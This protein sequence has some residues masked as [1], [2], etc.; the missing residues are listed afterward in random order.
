METKNTFLLKKRLIDINVDTLERHVEVIYL[1]F[2]IDWA[3]DEVLADTIDLVE[4]ADVCATWFVTHDTPLLKRL[5]DNPKF[6]LGIHPNFNNILAGMPEHANGMSA[7]ETV[8]R[9]LSLVPEAK[10]VRS[11]SMT[12]SSVLLKL[13]LDKGLTHDCNH[14][15]PHQAGIE[16]RPWYLWTDLIKVPYFWEDDASVIYGENLG[17]IAQLTQRKG[18]KVFDFHPIHVFLN[19]ERME[20]YEESRPFHRLPE[21]LLSFRNNETLGVRTALKTLLELG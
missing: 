16:L 11:H 21:K 17:E 10:S 15:I 14:F 9:L 18:L 3:C 1:T 19:T 8:D 13:F 12:Q 20:R 6:E 7:E 4:E 5:R 2:D